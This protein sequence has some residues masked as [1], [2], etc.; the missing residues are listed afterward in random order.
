MKK[1]RARENATKVMVFAKR[2][3]ANSTDI[4]LLANSTPIMIVK[5]RAKKEM[6]VRDAGTTG[7][8][9]RISGRSGKECQS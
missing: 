2:I 7:I 1:A 3:L 6:A 5:Y 8:M 4:L 9:D